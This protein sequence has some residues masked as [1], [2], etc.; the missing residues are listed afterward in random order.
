MQQ[1]VTVVVQVKEITAVA[2]HLFVVKAA[3][4]ADVGNQRFVAAEERFNQ[5]F[6]VALYPAI[7]AVQCAIAVAGEQKMLI[8]LSQV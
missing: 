2:A 8:Y 4:L 6:V 7:V 5:M 1:L 3:A